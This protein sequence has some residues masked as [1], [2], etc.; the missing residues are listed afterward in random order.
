[1]PLCSIRRGVPSV[2]VVGLVNV[3]NMIRKYTGSFE[4]YA[5]SLRHRYS[6]DTEHYCYLRI[7][8]ATTTEHKLFWINMHMLYGLMRIGK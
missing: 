7:N 1:M 6:I 3:D 4:T 8:K 2:R 5:K